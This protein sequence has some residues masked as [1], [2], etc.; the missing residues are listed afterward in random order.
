MTKRIDRARIDAGKVELPKKLAYLAADKVDFQTILDRD[1]EFS[2]E[3]SSK[4]LS[5][6][7]KT[8]GE[9]KTIKADQKS[10][11]ALATAALQAE[12]EAHEATKRE[13]AKVERQLKA[14]RKKLEAQ[15]TPAPA[16]APIESAK[17]AAKAP[18]TG[19][20]VAKA[21]ART[22][23][24][25]ESPELAPSDSS[26]DEPLALSQESAVPKAVSGETRLAS[27]VGEA[28]APPAAPFAP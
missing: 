4:A 15:T 2:I 12:Q 27:A 1:G 22:S 19:R 7:V 28:L 9:L 21:G 14:L 26:S 3:L 10:A 11:G 17:T 20:P 23:A 18:K 25:K 24:R 6:L 5:R 8:K 13:L 16:P